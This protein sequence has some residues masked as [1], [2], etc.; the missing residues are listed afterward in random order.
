MYIYHSSAKSDLNA[1]VERKIKTLHAND[2]YCLYDIGKRDKKMKRAGVRSYIKE[3]TFGGVSMTVNSACVHNK[4]ET[5]QFDVRNM[6]ILEMQN[7]YIINV[8]VLGDPIWDVKFMK[9]ILSIQGGNKPMIICVGH[10]EKSKILKTFM[11]MMFHKTKD[12]YCSQNLQVFQEKR[13]P[14][15]DIELLALDFHKHVNLQ[16]RR[17]NTKRALDID[18]DDDIDTKRIRVDVTP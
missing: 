15:Q 7:I 11:D 12:I 1:F 16:I 8:L 6:L 2:V 18:T 10:I 14:K 13:C 17:T 5:P 4:M 3:S 9:H